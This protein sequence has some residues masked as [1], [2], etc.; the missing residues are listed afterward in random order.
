MVTPSV[1]GRGRK[2]PRRAV[3]VDRDGVINK[4][5]VRDGKSYPPAGLDDFEIMPG[6]QEAV[7]LLV[8]AGFLL[9]VATNQPD[10]GRGTQRKD[11]VEAMHAL[12][13]EQLAIDDIKVCYEVETPDSTHYKPAP[14]MLLDAADDHG[15]DVLASYMVGDRWRDI[16]AGKAVG[17]FTIHLDRGYNERRPEAPDATVQS[18]LEAAHLILS[19]EY[20]RDKS[21][22]FVNARS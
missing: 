19:R 7:D 9:I 14:G 2:P 11:V 5:P 20:T 4:A 1:P 18:L 21:D 17:C 10:V 12:L 22:E 15:I 16:G 8:K 3:F 6:V 13:R